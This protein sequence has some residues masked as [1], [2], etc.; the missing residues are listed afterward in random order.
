[1]VIL[2]L[3]FPGCSLSSNNNPI[4]LSSDVLKNELRGVNP[5][6]WMNEGFALQLLGENSTSPSL[7][8][9][10]NIKQDATQSNK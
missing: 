10:S 2:A 6:P 9:A 7:H 5:I 1:L 8:E 4:V 3:G